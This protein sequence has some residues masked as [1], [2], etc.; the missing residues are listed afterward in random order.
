MK[1]CWD[2]LQVKGPIYG[3]YPK[4]LI[5]YIIAKDQYKQNAKEL[6]SRTNISITVSGAKHLGA[7][8][9]RVRSSHRE[10][11]LGKGVLKI[12][13]KFTGEHPCRSVISIKLLCN[14]IEITLRH[15]CSPVNLLHIFRTPFSKNTS[16]RLLLKSNLQRR[17][18]Q[19]AS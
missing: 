1:L 7:V 3:C 14:F 12:C 5:Y 19:I 4:L 8:I 15:G 16:G 9:G 6:F 10:V 11:F 18:H 17:L 13:S 2:H